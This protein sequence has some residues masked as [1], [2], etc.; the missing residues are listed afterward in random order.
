MAAALIATSLF[1]SQMFPAPAVNVKGDHA[2]SCCAGNFFSIWRC[3]RLRL[4]GTKKDFPFAAEHSRVL[5][6]AKSSAN[7]NELWE[8][9]KEI[10]DSEDEDEDKEAEAGENDLDFES[11][12]EA[13]KGAVQISN[14]IAELSASNYEDELIKEVE[15]LLE[16]EELAI[17]QHN[18]TP[19]MK[20]ISSSKWNSLHTLALAG[21]IPYMDRLLEEGLNIDLVDKDG[22]TALHQAIIGKKE[23]VISHLLRKG[24]N[25]HAKDLDGAT[26]LHYAVQVG[27]VQTVKLL[28]KHGVDVNVT[29]NEGWTPLHVAIQS[30]NRDIAKLLLVNGAD[31]NITNKDGKT[32]LDLSLCYGKDFKSYDLAKLVK[33]VPYNR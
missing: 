12:W 14:R 20:K 11:D 28:I 16:P 6:C 26:P 31:K 15:Q 8:D 25:L 19:D 9:P 5:V 18:M 23:A 32:P 10:S 2:S 17:L 4:G 22:L 1:T 21:Q 24:A 27:A 33:L 3:G 7:L 13:D 30:R 29:D